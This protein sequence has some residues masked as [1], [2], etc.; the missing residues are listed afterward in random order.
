MSSQ[1]PR[2]NFRTDKEILYKLNFIAEYNGRTSNKEIEFIV[3]QYITE[4]EK[5]HGQI[6]LN[7]QK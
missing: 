5:K 6:N 2:Y 4:F 3:K 7:D 1:L